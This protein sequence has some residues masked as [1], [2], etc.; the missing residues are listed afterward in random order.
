MPVPVLEGLSVRAKRSEL[1]VV[2][3]Y[4]KVVVYAPI[5]SA[6]LAVGALSP[7]HGVPP[8]P[9]QLGLVLKMLFEESMPR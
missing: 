3:L 6:L 5:D 4:E 1:P 7:D 8:P 2:A 9:V